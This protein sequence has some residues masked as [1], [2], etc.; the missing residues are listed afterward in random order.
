MCRYVG[1]HHKGGCSF[2]HDLIRYAEIREGSLMDVTH[3]EMIEAEL[4]RFIE[5]RSAR[6][7]DPDEQEELWKESVR[8]YNV[9]RREQNRLAWS[10]RARAEEYDQRAALL[11]DPEEDGR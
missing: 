8:R 9:R 7:I 1:V 3:G 4:N 11:E 5:K 6:K 2:G 10:L